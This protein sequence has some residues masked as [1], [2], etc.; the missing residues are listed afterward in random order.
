MPDL[1]TAD[2]TEFDVRWTMVAKG[3]SRE[4]RLQVPATDLDGAITAA[5][6]LAYAINDGCGHVWKMTDQVTISAVSD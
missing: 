6:G 5:H 3:Q 4:F 2:L 1:T